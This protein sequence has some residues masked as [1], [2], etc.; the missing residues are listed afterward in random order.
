M[1]P[2]YLIL[3]YLA[4]IILTA[5]IFWY[6]GRRNSKNEAIDLKFSIMYLNLE[7]ILESRPV[8]EKSMNEIL[9]HFGQ[10]RKLN[11]P[12]KEKVDVLW[13][14]YID[15]YHELGREILSQDEHSPKMI[16]AGE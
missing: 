5:R 10:L 16:F 7:T 4:F 9:G 8:T 11:H 12:N 1:K 15:K 3:G 2:I 14:K 6:I 13:K